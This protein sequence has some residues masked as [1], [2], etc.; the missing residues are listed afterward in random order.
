MKY[1]VFGAGD[2]AKLVIS[3]MIIRWGRE[4]P[5]YLVD[6]YHYDF[7]YKAYGKTY[8]VF[9]SMKLLEENKDDVLIVISSKRCHRQIAEQLRDMGFMEGKHFF[10]WPHFVQMRWQEAGVFKSI[11]EIRVSCMAN[12]IAA[13]SKSVLDLGCGEMFL[14]KYLRDGIAY[15][16]CD[17]VARDDNTIICDLNKGEYPNIH[18]DT[19]FMSGILEHIDCCEEVIHKACSYAEREIIVSYCAIDYQSDFVSRCKWGAVN[20]FSVLDIA[21]MFCKYEMQLSFSKFMELP[22]EVLFRFV[23]CGVQ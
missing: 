2:D 1:V 21:E 3:N 8:P 6:N 7:E 11:F 9:F 16:P 23:K 10:G 5:V 12:L 19:V 15:Y 18:T 14:R 4:I 22:G 13:D 17:Y 20:H